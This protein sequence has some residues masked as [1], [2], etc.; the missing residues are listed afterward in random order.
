[1]GN[2]IRTAVCPEHGLVRAERNTT[3][4]LAGW[5]V[6][7]RITPSP[8]PRLHMVP[9]AVMSASGPKRTLD[10]DSSQLSKDIVDDARDGAGSVDT[11]PGREMFSG[12]MVAEY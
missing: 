9:T 1:M 7:S 5:F 12:A 3:Y 11:D 6:D 4:D 8:T 10:R 2:A